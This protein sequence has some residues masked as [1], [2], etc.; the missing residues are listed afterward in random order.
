MSD[1]YVIRVCNIARSPRGIGEVGDSIVGLPGVWVGGAE[2][3][4]LSFSIDHCGIS[5]VGVINLYM[6][7]SLH[8]AG[9]CIGPRS[10][11]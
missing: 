4:S 10:F 1:T 11:R 2:I 7:N 8:A 9:R 5:T 3:G 6:F